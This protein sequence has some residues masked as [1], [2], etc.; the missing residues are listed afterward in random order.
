LLNFLYFSFFL[1]SFLSLS[2]FLFFF[3]SY[4]GLNSWPH[5][6][7]DKCFTTGALLPVLFHFL[8]IITSTFKY[9][10]FCQHEIA[11]KSAKNLKQSEKAAFLL[12][13]VFFFLL[14]ST[15][16]FLSTVLVFCC[17]TVNCHKLDSLQHHPLISTICKL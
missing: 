17:C 15:R 12:P 8:R 11:N 3:L 9:T 1:F 16:Q 5:A 7:L 10:L 13:G 14:L 2:V 6:C 4:W